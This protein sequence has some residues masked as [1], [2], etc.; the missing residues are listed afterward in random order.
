MTAAREPLTA[1]ALADLRTRIEDGDIDWPDAAEDLLAEVVRL[2][3]PAHRAQ[4][5]REAVEALPID[6]KASHELNGEMVLVDGVP[7]SRSKLLGALI[8]RET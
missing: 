1:E 2:R 3:S 4:I 5:V 8:P 7:L 6:D